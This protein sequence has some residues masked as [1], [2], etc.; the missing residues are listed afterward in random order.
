[1]KR[2]ANFGFSAPEKL[3]SRKLC[4]RRNESISLRRGE[5][6][7]ARSGDGRHRG[8]GGPKARRVG[9]GGEQETSNPHEHGDRRAK[10]S[11]PEGFSLRGNQ[12]PAHSIHRPRSS[13][14]DSAMWLFVYEATLKKWITPASPC[15]L[16]AHPLFG[17]MLRRKIS[18][19]DLAK[20][21]HTT[22]R[23]LKFQRLQQLLTRRIF[24]H[25][26]RYF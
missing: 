6:L 18:F 12:N 20:N 11:H 1:L 25:V 10:K 23:E 17:A 9:G 3:T 4:N 22:R 16:D 19:Y 5:S 15:F 2:L 24:Q 26:E 7:R 13:K 8:G 21:V 14:E